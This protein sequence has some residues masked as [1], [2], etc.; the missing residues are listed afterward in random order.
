[1]YSKKAAGL[2]TCV[3][4]QMVDHLDLEHAERVPSDTPLTNSEPLAAVARA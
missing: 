3:E 2:S 1:M 4:L